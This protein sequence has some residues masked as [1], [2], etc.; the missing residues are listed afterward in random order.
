MS[1]PADSSSCLSSVVAMAPLLFG[2]LVLM[3][4]TPGTAASSPLS[5][6]EQRLVAA[7]DEHA[8]GSLA[9]LEQVVNMNSGTMNFAGVRAVGAI[10]RTEFEG[11]G[12]TV[13]W[14]DGNA[15]NRA[16]HLVAERKS[17][18]AGAPKV[19]LIGHLDTVFEKDSPFQRFETLPGSPARAK[20]PGVNDMKGGDVIMLLA[21]RAL[22]DA[23]ELDRL[24]V[25]AVLM[26]DEED[27]GTPLSLARA[28]LVAAAEHADVALGFEDGDGKF[29]NAVISR[30][31]ASGWT[32]KVTGRP[33]HSSQIFV[34][35]YGD[36]AI[37][38]MARILDG[39]RRELSSEPYL[40]FNPGVAIGGTAVDFDATE[41]R[42]TV[43]GK[44][45]VIAQGAVVTGDLRTLSPEQH[46]MAVKKMRAIADAH[47]PQTSAELV[48][49]EGYPPM[50]P[51]EGNHRLL[52]LFDQA[53]RDLGMGEVRPVDPRDAGAA[54]ISF[55]ATRVPMA[56]DALGL[57]GTGGHTV[58]ETAELSTLAPQAKRVALLLSRL[59][60]GSK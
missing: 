24:S 46:D 40:T 20:G 39:F 4:S 45:N 23:G 30:R 50:A 5:K 6:T 34:E 9:L 10:F 11:L 38:E 27:S 2:L 14:V 17:A 28:D 29:E 59:R 12:F 58:E 42:G 57:K 26:G 36:G 52:A 35:G 47:L 41:L 18:K 54:D 3:A 15:F 51:T 31:S 22:R 55:I 60:S 16:G 33:A 53:S 48:F 1:A 13:R 49:D 56:L 32:L 8:A 21:L 7:V 25:T 19:L 37:Y 43:A 44:N